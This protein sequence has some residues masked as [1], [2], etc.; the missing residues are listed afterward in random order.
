MKNFELRRDRFNTF[1]AYENPSLNISMPL[2]V[3]DFRPFCTAHQL[4]PFHFFLYCLLMSVREIDNFMYR[5][6]DGEVIRIDDFYAS[7]TAI[8]EDHNYNYA[9]FTR[10]D[11]LDEFVERSVAA[12]RQARTTR[13]LINTGAHLTPRERK[14]N[15]FTTCMPWIDLG[16]IAHPVFCYKEPD[17]PMIA[18]GRFSAPGGATMTLPFSVQAHHGF[19]DAYHIHL[20]GQA[21]AKRIGA[22]IA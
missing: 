20:L 13:E 1:R 10:S 15:I 18:W 12:G 7:F 22:T 11:N 16:A 17:I 4:P 9:S 19:V 14:N 3:P 21:L 2:A 5:V 6:H 8:N